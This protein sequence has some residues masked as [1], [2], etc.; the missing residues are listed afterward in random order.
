MSLANKTKTYTYIWSSAELT[1]Q[2]ICASMYPSSYVGQCMW[3]RSSLWVN[4][5]WRCTCCLCCRCH[6]LCHSTRTKEEGTHQS[7]DKS[8]W[9][10]VTNLS[11]TVLG[12]LE[13]CHQMGHLEGKKDVQYI[14]ILPK[15]A[16][17]ARASALCWT[18]AKQSW[19]TLEPR[20]AITEQIQSVIWLNVCFS[21]G[22]LPGADGDII[23]PYFFP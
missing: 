5:V 16:S 2:R 7:Q 21:T 6:M 17:L 15:K 20:K 1:L 13:H 23:S 14:T 11:R 22:G 19:R 10:F 3:L 12:W 9:S 18:S 4:V 8:D